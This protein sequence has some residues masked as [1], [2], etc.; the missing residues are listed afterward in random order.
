MMNTDGYFASG[1]VEQLTNQCESWLAAWGVRSTGASLF[2]ASFQQYWRNTFAYYSPIWNSMDWGTSLGFGGEQ[3]ELIKMAVPTAKTLATQFATLITRPRIHYEAVTDAMST[4]PLQDAR[5]AKTLMN[6]DAEE[7]DFDQL[8]YE[9]ALCA[10]VKADAFVSATYRRDMGDVTGAVDSQL[11]YTGRNFIEIHD[12]HDVVYDWTVRNEQSRDWVLVR[13]AVNRYVL[14]EMHPQ[15][16][17]QI[18]GVPSCNM[19]RQSMP[20]WF[21]WQTFD[22]DDNIYLRE[23]YH[24]PNAVLPEGRMTYFL[25]DGTVLSDDVNEYEALPVYPLRFDTFNQ[26]SLGYAPFTD[27]L[28]SQEIMDNLISSIATNQAA[29]G[30]QAVMVPKRSAITVNQ[31]RGMNFIEYELDEAGRPLKPE[32]LQLTS[33]PGELFTFVENLKRYQSDLS[34]INDNLRGNASANVTSGA[35]AATLSANAMEM[36]STSQKQIKKMFEW[37]GNRTLYNYKRFATEQQV[38]SIV[39]EGNISYAMDFVG[40]RDL[41]H[42]KQIRA[43]LDNPLLSTT[44]GRLNLVEM[45]APMLQSGNMKMAAKVAQIVNGAPID[46]IFDEEFSQEQAVDSEVEAFLQGQPIMP[47]ITDYA[48]AYAAKYGKLL[49]N[50][51]VRANSELLSQVLDIILARIQNWNQ[52]PPEIKSFLFGMEMPPPPEGGAAPAG[53][54]TQAPAEEAPGGPSAP[55]E[56]IPIQDAIGV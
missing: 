24:R 38:I 48:P 11:T 34:F 14:A 55:A 47:A 45:L 16:R 6:N 2:G 53:I 51:R 32:P 37:L 13:R 9:M 40:S 43:R 1:S 18:L 23:F 22:C 29:F 52:L 42:V 35:M 12:K 28:P 41:K 19:E 3:G 26:T 44:S 39:G 4:R 5:L 8:G 46:V 36:M 15:F 7:F 20:N 54:A 50:P 10:Y 27:L 49:N 25:S 56:P 33:T 21:G 31:L 17:D 30:V